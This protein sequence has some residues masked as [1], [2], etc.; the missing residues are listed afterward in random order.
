MSPLWKSAIAWC[1][2]TTALAA[3][4]IGGAFLYL[5]SESYVDS[6][7]IETHIRR[8]AAEREFKLEDA[9]KSGYTDAEIA[10][11]LSKA[12]RASFDRVWSRILIT[13][14]LLYV[15]VILGITSSTLVRE[16]RN[17]ARV[18]DI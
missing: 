10:A 1:L 6:E 3:S 5:Q 13:I 2:A 9:R 4:A 17:S 18:D 14:G 16:V 11:F 12:D 7:Y 15:V 8:V